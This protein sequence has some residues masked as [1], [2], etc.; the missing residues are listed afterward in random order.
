MATKVRRWPF[1]SSHDAR[2]WSMGATI[3]LDAQR[4]QVAGKTEE[5]FFGMEIVGNAD[6]YGW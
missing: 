5:S 1:R 3:R 6:M 2:L 4:N